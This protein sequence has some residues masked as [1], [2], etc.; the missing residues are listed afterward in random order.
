[1]ADIPDAIDTPITAGEVSDED[2]AAGALDFG[3]AVVPDSVTVLGNVVNVVIGRVV[4][5]V[6]VAV[7]FA[8]VINVLLSEVLLTSAVVG[9]VDTPVLSAETDVGVVEDNRVVSVT[10]D[11]LV[12]VIAP[13]VSGNAPETSLQI[14]YPTEPSVVTTSD[15][16][17][18]TIHANDASPR[19]RPLVV[20][21]RQRQSTSVEQQRPAAYWVLIKS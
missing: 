6:A 17:E 14:A 5:A 9:V 21:V 10:T 2:V 15:E 4:A 12:A 11:T 16:H 7:I 3:V 20:F 13:C 18:P 8:V 19:V 1:M